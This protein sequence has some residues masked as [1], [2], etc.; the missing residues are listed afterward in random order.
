M[1]SDFNDQGNLPP[2][3]HL[4]TWEEFS[5]RFG[6]N[7][8]RKKLLRGLRDALNNLK[9]CG[10]KTVYIDGSFTTCKYRPHDFDGCWDLD[11]VNE[12]KLDPILKNFDNGR[13]AQKAKYFG[14]FFASSKNNPDFLNFFQRDKE[15]GDPK[16]IICINL[17]EYQ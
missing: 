16:G 10:C 9:S 3:I 8:Y 4:A 13:Q 5:E 1:I 11:G 15:T 14:E 12:E 6:T 2:G 7:Y 17:E